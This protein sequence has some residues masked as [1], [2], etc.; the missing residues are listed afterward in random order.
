MRRSEDLLIRWVSGEVIEHTATA[1]DTDTG[2]VDSEDDIGAPRERAF[3]SEE[4]RV[5][6]RERGGGRAAR[7][8]RA[9]SI[10]CRSR[11]SL[12]S[13]TVPSGAVAGRP[14]TRAAAWISFS[15]WLWGEKRG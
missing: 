1:A 13:F 9:S 11:S 5:A 3:P 8:R 7:G 12:L 15:V 10:R 6:E 14:R 2:S 4:N